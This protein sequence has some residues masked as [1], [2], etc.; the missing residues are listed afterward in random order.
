[1]K[2]FHAELPLLS[3]SLDLAVLV[4]VILDQYNPLIGL[5]RGVPFLVLILLTCLASI[6]TAVTL[7]ASWR[8]K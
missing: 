3:L 1:M 6:G 2:F 5:L 8:K 4:L 7:Y